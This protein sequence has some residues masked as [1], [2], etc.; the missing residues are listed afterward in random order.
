MRVDQGYADV[1]FRLAISAPP[2]SLT[3]K[4]EWALEGQTY[5]WPN[6]NSQGRKRE[7]EV[8]FGH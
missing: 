2:R 1:G 5:L 4:V 8:G 6:P 7:A 3:E